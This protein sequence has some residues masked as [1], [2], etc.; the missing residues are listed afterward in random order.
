MG[1]FG[2]F[3]LGGIVGA[4]VALLFAPRNGEETRALVAEKA[5]EYW[6]KGQTWYGEG[7]ARVQEGVAGVQPAINR[8]GD[9]LR[10][11]IDNA[12]TLIAEQVA[13]NAAAARDVINDKMPVAAEKIG[14]A[15]DVVRGRIDGA[16]TLIKDK[17]AA[18]K[19]GDDAAVEVLEV[20]EAPEKVEPTPVDSAAP[21]A[22]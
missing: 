19:G 10:E 14:Q 17:A 21:V 7:K 12:R 20:A 9:E 2:S 22:S 1:R 11:K 18:I 3:L 6:G 16:A 5:D 8:T 15:A 4:G 13:K